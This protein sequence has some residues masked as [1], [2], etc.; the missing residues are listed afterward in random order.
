MPLHFRRHH[1]CCCCC[2]QTVAGR[3][4]LSSV[5][6]TCKPLEST[7]DVFALAMYLLNAWDT[8][9]MGNYPYPDSYLTNGGAPCVVVVPSSC[10]SVEQL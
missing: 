5:F 9:A 1:V 10:G 7:D 3:Q 2:L 8:M 6:Q 4:Q